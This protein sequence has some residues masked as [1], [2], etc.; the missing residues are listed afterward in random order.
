LEGEEAVMPPSWDLDYGYRRQY[1]K[2]SVRRGT[3]LSMGIRDDPI[4][5]SGSADSSIWRAPAFVAACFLVRSNREEGLF[6]VVGGTHLRGWR[7]A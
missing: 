5:R 2:R 4:S 1:F 6:A 7:A 3:R